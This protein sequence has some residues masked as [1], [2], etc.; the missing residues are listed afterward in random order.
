VV[1]SGI[2]VSAVHDRQSSRMPPARRTICRSTA[3]ASAGLLVFGL[4]VPG[5]LAARWDRPP[6]P[7]SSPLAVASDTI[8]PTVTLLSPNGGESWLAGVSQ[9]VVWT[10]SDNAGVVSVD[11]YY[12]DAEGAPWTALARGIGNTGSRAWF[13][14]SLPTSSARL[15]V[16]VRDGAGNSGE[17]LSDGPFAIRRPPGG[18]LPTTLRD[19][20][21]PGSRPLEGGRFLENRWCVCHTYYDPAVEPGHNFLGSMMAV[22]TYDPMFRACLAIAEQDAPA[23]GDLCLRCHAPMGWLNG[24]SQPTDGSQLI[25]PDL[26]GVACDFC[27]HL[28]DPIYRPGVSPP[29][30]EGI[31]NA[32]LPAHRPAGY[33]NGQYVTDPVGGRRGPF[34]NVGAPHLYMQ[35][36][37]MRSGDLCGT[38]HDLSNPLLARVSGADYAPGPY[39]QPADS[40]NSSTLMPLERT[41][42]EWKNSAYPSGVYAPEL[43]GNKPDGMVAIC[44]DCHLPDVIGP[45][46]DVLGAPVRPDQ[47]LHDLS[48]GS[49][50]LPPLIAQL[51]PLETNAVALADGALRA[52]ARLRKAA[53]LGMVVLPHGP[54]FRATVTVTNRAGHKLP[55]GFPEA[56][57]MWIHLVARDASGSVVYQSG[58]YDAGTGLLAA[59]PAPVVYEARLGLSPS[60]AGPIGLG[61]GPSFHF[62][63][64]DTVY[65]DNRIPPL[66]F[67][68]AAFAAFG[69]SPVE[70]GRPTP[71]YADGQNWDV[72]E[73]DLPAAAAMVTAT[74]LYQSVT[75]EYAEFLRDENH[76]NGAG[77]AFYDLWAAN[78]RCPPQVMASDSVEIAPV[79]A[80][81]DAAPPA[82]C[83]TLGANPFLGSLE[84]RLDLEDATRV[85]LEVFDVSGRRL[86]RA[87]H[88]WLGGGTH[89]LGWDGREAGGRDAGAGAFWVRV[90]AGERTWLRRVVRLR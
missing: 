49:V 22:A 15:R 26:D 59:D 72:A 41:Y 88:G 23:S 32:L 54:G 60:H 52:S 34:F 33:S 85:V 12:R 58:A 28:V 45:G 68:N 69:G 73:F 39:D 82:P 55:T 40:L 35:S 10:A 66:G 5:V 29:V 51:H 3:L 25:F 80:P 81:V 1:V 76:T 21:Q 78:G 14:P 36:P 53:V 20:Q 48:G 61:A 71:R 57:R 84:L 64:N 30:D 24:H 31:L 83:L 16:V 38:C 42:S 79:S 6:Q 63:L 44:Q 19:F 4:S 75:K 90:Q 77:Q 86:A 17:D 65:Q 2:T 87:D 8:P 43:A 18:V 13:V 7:G 46:C 56:R 74:L 89:R 62:A 67:S 47:P 9:P 11:L 50:W 27:H 70:P 37:F